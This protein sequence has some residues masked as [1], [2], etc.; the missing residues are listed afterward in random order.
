[1]TYH[2]HVPTEE[3]LEQLFD[4]HKAALAAH[5][6]AQLAFEHYEKLERGQDNWSDAHHEA[7]LQKRHTRA[8]ALWLGRRLSILR[9]IR[10][11]YLANMLN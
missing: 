2:I 3:E 7:L 4:E 1:M 5:R 6:Q 8:V 9:N 11:L 10:I